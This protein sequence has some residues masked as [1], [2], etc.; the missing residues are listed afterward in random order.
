MGFSSDKAAKTRERKKKKKKK[1]GGRKKE[2]K[3]RL[4]YSVMD[5]ASIF[6]YLLDSGERAGAFAV[7][8]AREEEEKEKEMKE[9]GRK[10]PQPCK[11]ICRSILKQ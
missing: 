10:S 9:A 6:V 11:S 5:Q 4:A 7:N 3:N 2:G 8:R 1:K